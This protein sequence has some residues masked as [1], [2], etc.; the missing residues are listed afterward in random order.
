MQTN[1]PNFSEG[2]DK[3]T[4]RVQGTEGFNSRLDTAAKDVGAVENDWSNVNSLLQQLAQGH[5]FADNRAK[6]NDLTAG[7]AV[8][9][10]QQDLSAATN[11]TASLGKALMRLGSK[12]ATQQVAQQAEAQQQQQMQAMQHA[13]ALREAD[14]QAR[15]QMYK[16]ELMLEDQKFQMA[17]ATQQMKDGL[18]VANLQL[19]N[20]FNVNLAKA[21]N[22]QELSELDVQKHNFNQVMAYVGAGLGAASTITAAGAAASQANTAQNAAD[23]KEAAK[24]DTESSAQMASSTANIGR[25]FSS[26]NNRATFGGATPVVGQQT[27]PD[28]LKQFYGENIG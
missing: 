20:L 16:K 12:A 9:M 6:G 17:R 26:M 8:R 18:E 24:Y 28:Y 1:P 7:Q 3:N 19:K 11:D 5:A 22:Q 2:L 27:A 13:A 25:N 10:G 4:F 21:R 15:M 14:A 23:S